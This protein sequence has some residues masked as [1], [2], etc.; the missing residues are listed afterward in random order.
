M[1]R[2]MEQA[3]IGLVADVYR[4]REQPTPAWLQRPGR[5]ECGRRWSLVYDLYAELTGLEL[6]DTMPP[7]DRRAIDC[8]L[9]RRGEPPR[10]IEFDEIQHF[11]RYRAATIRRYPSSVRVAF[12]RAAWLAACDAKQR[13]EGGGFG[14]PRPP[15][16][17]HADGRHR[18]RAFR[19]ALADVLPAV[20]GWLPT[21]RIAD[22]EVVGWLGQRG[23]KART[24]TLVLG[25]IE[26]GC[27][28][29]RSPNR[30]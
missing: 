29:A 28:R 18:Q 21:L 5:P 10:L 22:F 3:V 25:G 14:R 24:A 19:D 2:E 30:P 4:G 15:L 6:P 26:R 20:H 12:D 9:Q 13:L 11:N 17:P 1:P 23:A 27:G 8:V 7:R 16:F